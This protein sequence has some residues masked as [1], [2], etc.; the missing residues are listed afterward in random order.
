MA[1]KVSSLYLIKVQNRHS[2]IFYAICYAFVDILHRILSLPYSI[3][4]NIE[5]R[6]LIISNKILKP[7]WI[8]C[9]EIERGSVGWRMGYGES[10]LMK[11]NKWFNKLHPGKKVQY[12]DKYPEPYEWKGFYK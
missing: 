3:K 11:W 1:N 10:Y 5:N 9:S 4:E 12:K 7:P 2:N 6:K 8:E